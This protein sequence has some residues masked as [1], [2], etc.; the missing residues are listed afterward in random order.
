MQE[1]ITQY[2]TCKVIVYDKEYDLITKITQ[3]SKLKNQ[4]IKY[5]NRLK[6]NGSTIRYFKIMNTDREN[7]SDSLTIGRYYI[8]YAIKEV[9]NGHRKNTINK[10]LN[11]YIKDRGILRDYIQHIWES[12]NYLKTSK[13]PLN[14]S[15]SIMLSMMAYY[16]CGENESHILSDKDEKDIKNREV[17]S[18]KDI[19]DISLGDGNY[20]TDGI[21]NGWSYNISSKKNMKKFKKVNQ[22]ATNRW[23]RTTT[24]KTNDIVSYD[25]NKV[26]KYHWKRKG[27]ID[28][29]K[30]YDSKWCIVD[31]ENVFEFQDNK[32]EISKEVSQYNIRVKKPNYDD[33]K[34]DYQ[35][36]KILVYEQDGNLFFFDQNIKQ[37]NDNM[38]FEV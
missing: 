37:I 15:E 23:K 1:I 3:W 29:E 18:F 20:K 5:I 6:K 31:T 30:P 25:N 28:H 34:L 36:D 12:R 24:Y 22:G 21:R 38:I 11:K 8:L 10:L 16:L 9:D 7:E 33:Y 17:A 4:N 27:L 35:M 13:A 19:G 2:E 32:Y 14:D 26:G